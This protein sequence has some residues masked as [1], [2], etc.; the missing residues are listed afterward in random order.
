MIPNSR[1]AFVFLGGLALFA[2]LLIFG[3]DTL[4][5]RVPT[6]RP[7]LPPPDTETEPTPDS[8][9]EVG[10]D[11]AP[12]R[13]ERSAEDRRPLIYGSGG[14]QPAALTIRETDDLGCAIT[15]INRS[16][17]LLGIG[18]DPHN[19]AGDPGANYGQISPGEG[20]VIDTRYNLPNGIRLHNHLNPEHGFAVTYGPGCQ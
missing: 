10:E 16:S 8:A 13:I 2:L 19:P 18:V 3:A 12:F 11:G 9:P 20:A 5:K 7:V 4:L 15:V 1:K 14:F 17:T 6:P